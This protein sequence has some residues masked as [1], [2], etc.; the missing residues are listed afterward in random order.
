MG[1]AVFSTDIHVTTKQPNGLG[2]TK[3][4]LFASTG[5][6]QQP[7]QNAQTPVMPIQSQALYYLSSD[8]FV[9][10]G[11]NGQTSISVVWLAQDRTTVIA[12]NNVFGKDYRSAPAPAA[13]LL[14]L[15]QILAAPLNAVYAVTSYNCTW[16]SGASAG[17]VYAGSG[18]APNAATGSGAGMQFNQTQDPTTYQNGVAGSYVVPNGAVWT[19]PGGSSYVRINSTW[20]V[21]SNAITVSPGT[22]LLSTHNAGALLFAF[23]PGTGYSHADIYLCSCGGSG[24]GV[25][26]GSGK[27]Y[28]TSD[29]GGSGASSCVAI[30]VAVAP[31]ST[32]LNYN[33]PQTSGVNATLTGAGLNLVCPGGL[34]A[35]SSGSGAAPNAA[36][37]GTTNYRGRAGGLTHTWDGGGCYDPSGAVADNITDGSVGSGNGVGGSGTYFSSSAGGPAFLQVIARA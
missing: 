20:V 11:F 25:N 24:S 2:L 7:A 15:Q 3:A 34:D 12:V 13:A 5:G 30:G 19:V 31:G 27:S 29:T 14:G 1:A 28:S 37:G 16:P 22:I 10:A 35:T 9:L 4:I 36:T 21:T 6:S 8:Y 17:S 18:T 26:T 33:L 23:P 32:T